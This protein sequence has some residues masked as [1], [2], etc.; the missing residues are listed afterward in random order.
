MKYFHLK[1]IIIKTMFMITICIKQRELNNIIS[2]NLNNYLTHSQEIL[3]KVYCTY[4]YTL[5]IL[6]P[7]EPIDIIGNFIER[8]CYKR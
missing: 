8:Y 4:W 1:Y 3:C 5:M 6:I 2:I 7:I